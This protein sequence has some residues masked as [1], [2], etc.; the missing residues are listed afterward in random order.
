MQGVG[1]SVQQL[2]CRPKGLPT[3]HLMAL[4]KHVR[5]IALR[6]QAPYRRRLDSKCTLRTA[7]RRRR[8]LFERCAGSRRARGSV[9]WDRAGLLELVS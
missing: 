5:R 7:P 9:C 4:H 3:S 1:I 6:E 8:G 2:A